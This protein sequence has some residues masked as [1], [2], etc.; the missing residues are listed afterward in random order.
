MTSW[1]KS[2]AVA[3]VDSNGP[4]SFSWSDEEAARLETEGVQ[5]G[6]RRRFVT[7]RRGPSRGGR[8]GRAGSR[9]GSAFDSR[10]HAVGAG[11]LFAGGSRGAEE[12]VMSTYLRGS[13]RWRG[14]SSVGLG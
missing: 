4:A 3:R 6:S 12:S 14:L 8:W 10:R 9:G 7:P 13:A 1:E 5:V 11:F 2:T